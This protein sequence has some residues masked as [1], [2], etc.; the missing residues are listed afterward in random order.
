MTDGS[1][2]SGNGGPRRRRLIVMLI[3]VFGGSGLSAWKFIF[4][5]AR[6]PLTLEAAR[7]MA[8]PVPDSPEVRAEA[9]TLFTEQCANCHG[10]Q[11][12]GQGPEAQMYDPSPADFTNARRMQNM[13][14]GELFFRITEGRKPMPSFE[15]TLTE[16][17]RWK[18]VRYVRTFA[19]QPAAHQQK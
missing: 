15:K 16:E 3:V 8:N 2:E 5:G 13:R 9:K 18:L 6:R 17:Q 19:S 11:G 1:S 7:E 4:S 12:D 14:D 10:D